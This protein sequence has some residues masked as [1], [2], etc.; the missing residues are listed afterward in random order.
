MGN[1]SQPSDFQR[2][3]PEREFLAHSRGVIEFRPP[4][5]TGRISHSTR[6]QIIDEAIRNYYC[7]PLQARRRYTDRLQQLLRMRPN[8]IRQ[9]GGAASR[10][11]D[12]PRNCPRR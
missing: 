9:A 3:R 10:F 6:V 4:T 5:G 8:E 11:G 7:M 12:P 2:R 1:P